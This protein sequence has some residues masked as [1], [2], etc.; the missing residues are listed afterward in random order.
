M[1][2]PRIYQAQFK[3]IAGLDPAGSASLSSKP[4]R[5]ILGPVG[6]VLL[7]GSFQLPSV[8]ICGNGAPGAKGAEPGH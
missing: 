5:Y 2:T 4:P 3:F 6:V 7:S 8:V 1:Q